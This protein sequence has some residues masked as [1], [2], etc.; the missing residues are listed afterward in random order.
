MP[1]PNGAPPSA[2]GDLLGELEGL[3]PELPTTTLVELAARL[4]ELMAAANPE[5][6][7]VER[8]LGQLTDRP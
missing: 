5:L 7:E 1:D 3:V 4:D 2:A 8:M 6:G